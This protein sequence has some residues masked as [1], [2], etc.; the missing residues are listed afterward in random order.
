[1]AA[2]NL[3][4]VPPRAPPRRVRPVLTMQDEISHTKEAL[5]HVKRA[6]ELLWEYR[7]SRQQ[8]RNLRRREEA[9]HH[10]PALQR[11]QVTNVP[12]I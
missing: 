3:A 10:P 4:V 5:V 2:K 7:D 9:R 8:I 6:L 12:M 11:T 1:M